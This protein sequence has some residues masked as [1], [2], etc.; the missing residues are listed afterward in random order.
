MEHKN[1][2]FQKGSIWIWRVGLKCWTEQEVEVNGARGQISLCPTGSMY[3]QHE[4]SD[5]ELKIRNG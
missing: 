2:L 3:I 4:R 5:F 1:L